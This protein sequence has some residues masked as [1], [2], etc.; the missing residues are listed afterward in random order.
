MSEASTAIAELTITQRLEQVRAERA[1]IAAARDARAN[2]RATADELLIE[3]RG[4]NDDKALDDAEVTHG[5]VGRDIAVVETDLGNIIIK[6]AHPAIFKRFSDKSSLK[7]DDLETLVRHCLVHPSP[8]A[9]DHIMSNL[10]ATMLRCADAVS[11]LAGVRR[12]AVQG[13]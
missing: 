10:P 12:E 1:R 5:P 11:V 6:R 8:G 9:F 7:H 13:K 4:L 3:E 2:E